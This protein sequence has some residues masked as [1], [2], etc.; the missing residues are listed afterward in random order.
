MN[1]RRGFFGLQK[2]A[3]KI[4]AFGGNKDSGRVNKS[5]EVYDYVQN[6]WMN[7]PDMPKIGRGIT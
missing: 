3:K 6:S 4:F 2:M 5:A 1:N 7:L